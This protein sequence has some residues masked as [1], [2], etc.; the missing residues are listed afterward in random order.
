MMQHQPIVKRR[1]FQ[2]YFREW[3]DLYFGWTSHY[4]NQCWPDSLTHIYAPLGG[5]ELTHLPLVPHIYA[6]V[7]WARIGSGN[8][9][10]PVRRLIVNWTLENEPQW[11][12]SWYKTFHS[13]MKLHLKLSPAEWRPFCP[14]EM[15]HV[16]VL[17]TAEDLPL[18]PSVSD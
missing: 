16:A 6:S 12:T 18:N 14:G 4:L 5:D 11:K 10:S 15:C 17:M 2:M 3:K 8:G 9:L 1:Y 13:F 7:N